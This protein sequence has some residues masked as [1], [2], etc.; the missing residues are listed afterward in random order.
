[1]SELDRRY[2]EELARVIGPAGRLTIGED[3]LGRTIVTNFP[4]TLPA[5]FRAFCGL[6]AANEA[7]VAGDDRLTFGDLDR[8]CPYPGAA[9]SAGRV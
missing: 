2:D 9:T 1:M 3:E 7:V 4:A 6:N 8:I 5:F